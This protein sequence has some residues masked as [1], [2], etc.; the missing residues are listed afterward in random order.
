MSQANLPRAAMRP[1]LIRQLLRVSFHQKLLNRSLLKH[2]F[3]KMSG[4]ANF[5]SPAQMRDFFKTFR[6]GRP[7]K[8][9]PRRGLAV[10]NHAALGC[11]SNHSLKYAMV[12]GRIA[13]ETLKPSHIN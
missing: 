5:S 4:R 1:D 10:W 6:S 11:G 7:D 8:P 9:L 3:F 13:L 12:F 2:A